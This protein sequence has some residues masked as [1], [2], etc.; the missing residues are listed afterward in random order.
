[1]GGYGEQTN[2]N[3]NDM[4]VAHE[5]LPSQDRSAGWLRSR[6]YLYIIITQIGDCNLHTHIS[7]TELATRSPRQVV[8]QNTLQS[9]SMR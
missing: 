3:L 5:P 4:H 1:M 6:S 2:F 9:K 7:G 8:I